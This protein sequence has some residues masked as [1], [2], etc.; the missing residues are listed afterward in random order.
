MR[1]LRR[2]VSASSNHQ[3]YSPWYSL[4]VRECICNNIGVYQIEISDGA[5][6]ELAAL[7]AFDENRVL[8]AIEKQLSHEPNVETRNR[9]ILVGV[10]PPFE[11]VLPVWELRVEQ[12]RV[13]YD[14]SD[15][16]KKVYVRSVREKPPHKALEEIL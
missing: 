8:E 2:G 13:F 6:D 14:V 5:L 15:E 9:K 11:A 10:T 4:D 1:V 12:Y 7:R 16:N 3:T